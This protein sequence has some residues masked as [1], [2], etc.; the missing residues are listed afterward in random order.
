MFGRGQ[1]DELDDEEGE[2]LAQ[3]MRVE[4][5]EEVKRIERDEGVILDPTAS[6]LKRQGKL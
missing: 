5:A 1:R 3:S 2:R 6:D 4:L